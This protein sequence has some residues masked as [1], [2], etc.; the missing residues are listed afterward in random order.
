MPFQKQNNKNKQ[1]NRNKQTKNIKPSLNDGPA[2]SLTGGLP[3]CG[4]GYSCVPRPDDPGPFGQC[5]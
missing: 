5:V 2:C 3:V 4:S 1:N